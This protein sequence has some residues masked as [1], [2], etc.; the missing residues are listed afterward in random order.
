MAT[1]QCPFCNRTIELPASDEWSMHFCWPSIDQLNK[2]NSDTSYNDTGIG[3]FIENDQYHSANYLFGT[4]F[5]YGYQNIMD[6]NDLTP[7]HYFNF[8]M[9]NVMDMYGSP[10]LAEDINLSFSKNPNLWEMDPVDKT[11]LKNELHITGN[12]DRVRNALMVDTSHCES[13]DDVVNA[14]AFMYRGETLTNSGWPTRHAFSVDNES[15]DFVMLGEYTNKCIATDVASAMF[16]GAPPYP[17]REGAYQAITYPSESHLEYLTRFNTMNNFLIASGDSNPPMTD[18]GT[19]EYIKAGSSEQVRKR[20]SGVWLWKFTRTATISTSTPTPSNPFYLPINNPDAFRSSGHCRIAHVEDDAEYD[21]FEYEI[22]YDYY[23][24]Y[25]KLIGRTNGPTGPYSYEKGDLIYDYDNTAGSDLGPVVKFPPMGIHKSFNMSSRIGGHWS[26]DM[27]STLTFSNQSFD[28]TQSYDVY[29]LFVAARY[30]GLVKYSGGYDWSVVSPEASTDIYGSLVIG[31]EGAPTDLTSLGLT[32]TSVVLMQGSISAY[33]TIDVSKCVDGPSTAK[34]LDEILGNDHQTKEIK[35]WYLPKTEQYAVYFK[36][37]DANASKDVLYFGT[38]SG[39]YAGANDIADILNLNSDN[40]ASYTNYSETFGDWSGT[41]VKVLDGICGDT[42]LNISPFDYI[43]D[44][45]AGSMV[46]NTASPDMRLETEVTSTDTMPKTIDISKHNSLLHC[47]VFRPGGTEN[48]YVCIENVNGER[49][50]F[51]FDTTGCTDY[52]IRLTSRANSDHWLSEAN[53]EFTHQSWNSQYNFPVGSRVT[54]EIFSSRYPTGFFQLRIDVGSDIVSAIASDAFT[55]K[56]WAEDAG[57]SSHKI[58]LPVYYHYGINL[59]NTG[60][61]IA[62]C[63]HADI[64]SSLASNYVPI[65]DRTPDYAGQHN[66]SQE[67]QIGLLIPIRSFMEGSDWN[68]PSNHTQ[69]VI[70]GVICDSDGVELGGY[71]EET[72]SIY[73][74][75]D[76][77]LGYVS[78]DFGTYQGYT[79]PNTFCLP[80]YFQYVPMQAKDRQLPEG[81]INETY[82]LKVPR[83]MWDGAASQ[84]DDDIYIESLSDIYDVPI[85][86]K[87]AYGSGMYDISITSGSLPAGVTMTLHRN[88]FAYL[89]GTPTES[90][91]FTFDIEFEDLITGDTVTA[92]H[93]IFIEEPPLEATFYRRES[94]YG[95]ETDQWEDFTSGIIDLTLFYASSWYTT[96]YINRFTL[97]GSMNDAVAC[98]WG[99]TNPTI[100]FHG[101]NID[102]S[103]TRISGTD[104]N[105]GES[106]YRFEFYKGKTVEYGTFMVKPVIKTATQT[107]EGG[108]MQYYQNKSW[109]IY[110]HSSINIVDGGVTNSN[111]TI[112]YSTPSSPQNTISRE[113]DYDIE[114]EYKSGLAESTI[115]T[116]HEFWDLSEDTDERNLLNISIDGGALTEITI[117]DTDTLIT[118]YD[119]CSAIESEIQSSVPNGSNAT[120]EFHNARYYIFSNNAGS[121]S[122]QISAASD[123]L[124]DLNEIF[125]FTSYDSDDISSETWCSHTDLDA[126]GAPYTPRKANLTHCKRQLEFDNPD[127]GIYK[128][129]FAISNESNGGQFTDIRMVT[130]AIKPAGYSQLSITGDAPDSYLSENYGTHSFSYATSGGDSTS[131][132]FSIISGS[133]PDGLSLNTSTGE[134]TGT[135]DSSPGNIGVHSFTVAVTDVFYRESGGSLGYADISDTITIRE[136]QYIDPS[137]FEHAT[138]A[139]TWKIFKDNDASFDSECE[140][141]E[142]NPEHSESFDDAHPG[143]EPKTSDETLSERQKKLR[144]KYGG[145]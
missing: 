129:N 94:A 25:L 30:N 98:A 142:T 2:H 115:T 6:P 40:S 56:V 81:K 5:S 79:Y 38:P 96:S 127:T 69:W 32:G 57:D 50:F 26:D 29:P 91:T 136:I 92:E 20:I 122:V 143:I 11:T 54:T 16:E 12:V 23:S 130:Y 87:P 145:V 89:E 88:A 1:E 66:T 137:L 83:T 135:V 123:P 47:K 108:W 35:V 10:F 93:E 134:I 51:G 106:G 102:L 111:V 27:Y 124:K 119:I 28:T 9:W 104:I 101:G 86:I 131:L 17:G 141:E 52:Q 85:I 100:E 44:N 59:G 73:R 78:G 4:V 18:E 58:D 121:T 3:K 41:T 97:I 74:Y 53:T 22:Y 90:G 80:K 33:K 99:P 55:V 70:K 68:T 63:D 105:T 95:L 75:G 42:N 126:S 84:S 62:P 60:Q 140:D 72:A 77:D 82:A 76:D 15:V 61:T 8:R 48:G 139:E 113:F 103:T 7:G 109:S 14:I 19:L 112:G 36:Y 125:D 31:G 24:Y 34:H 114:F 138:T 110:G 107:V 118:P 116:D 21:I 46:T 67:K 128:Q 39:G 117:S 37:T 45:K 64:A 133:L 144:D 49:E 13:T 120:M 43:Q 132:E 65:F 71:S